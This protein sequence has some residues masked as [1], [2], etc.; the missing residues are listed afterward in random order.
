MLTLVGRALCVCR[1]RGEGEA[2]AE[3]DAETILLC[4]ALIWRAPKPKRPGWA[5][6][7]SPYDPR[8]V[9]VWAI[10]PAMPSPNFVRI[11]TS[12]LK[13]ALHMGQRG[14]ANA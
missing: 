13:R 1:G 14:S 9:P 11:T 8:H 4:C 3:A 10:V 2:N 5:A 7:A 12:L 6:V